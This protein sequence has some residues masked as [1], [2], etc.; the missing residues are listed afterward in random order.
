ML[1]AVSFL[2]AIVAFAVGLQLE[3]PSG[4][5]KLSD[6]AKLLLFSQAAFFFFLMLAALFIEIE[7]WKKH[8]RDQREREELLRLSSAAQVNARIVEF[9]DQLPEAMTH[10]GERLLQEIQHKWPDPEVIAENAAQATVLSLFHQGASPGGE[11]SPNQ[12]VTL[13][14]VQEERIVR[15]IVSKISADMKEQYR[16]IIEQ[17][18]VENRDL[19][20]LLRA[21]QA[22]GEKGESDETSGAKGQGRLPGYRDTLGP[23]ER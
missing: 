12:G 13:D 22:G 15:V 17:I 10:A 14:K 9:V 21:R 6:L 3:L 20:E 23:L 1:A 11:D 5:E 4:L 8:A 18:I 19:A 2:M 16:S 7:A